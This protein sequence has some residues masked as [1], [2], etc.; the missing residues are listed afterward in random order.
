MIAAMRAAVHALLWALLAGCM[1]P[2]SPTSAPRLPAAPRVAPPRVATPKPGLPAIPRLPPS[3]ARACT[4]AADCTFLPSLCER[5]DPCAPTWRSVGN[6]AEARRLQGLMARIR[7]PRPSCPPCADPSHWLGEKVVCVDG[8]CEPRLELTAEPD[9]AEVE[10]R[11]SRTSGRYHW[12][13]CAEYR[14][15][16]CTVVFSSKDQAERAGYR[17]CDRCTPIVLRAS[18]DDEPGRPTP[19]TPFSR[20]RACQHDR[21]C[22]LAPPDPCQCPA[23]GTL[24]R[25]ALNRQGMAARRALFAR[26][27]ECPAPSCTPCVTNA[28]TV[29]AVCSHRQCTVR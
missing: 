5:C 29:R 6:Q 14:C 23:C 21:D 24:G 28:T 9:T 3:K 1:T 26:R 10:L 16:D 27:G 7:C 8:Q 13:E 19:A 22:Q 17:P 18:G 20:E 4:S 2:T 15:Q 25:E 12:P 11:G